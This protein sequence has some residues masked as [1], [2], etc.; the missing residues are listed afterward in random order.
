MLNR[1]HPTVLRYA[2]GINAEATVETRNGGHATWHTQATQ[3]A[4]LWKW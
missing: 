4:W 2:M 1:D 3:V